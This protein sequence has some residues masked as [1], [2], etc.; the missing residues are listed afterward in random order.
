[1]FSGWIVFAAVIGAWGGIFADQDLRAPWPIA[2][3]VLV[4]TDFVL[5]IGVREVEFIRVAHCDAAGTAVCTEDLIR[6]D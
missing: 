5:E 6:I 4:V 1:M 3:K 2:P